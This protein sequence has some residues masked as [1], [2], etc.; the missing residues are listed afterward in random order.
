MKAL[1][2]PQETILKATGLSAEEL[3]KL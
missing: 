1:N 3:E 2:L